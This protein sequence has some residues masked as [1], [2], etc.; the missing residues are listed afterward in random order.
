MKHKE[1]IRAFPAPLKTFTQP[2]TPIIQH[3]ETQ[4]V[5]PKKCRVFATKI[6]N[7][8]IV[9]RDFDSLGLV[10]EEQASR[11][12]LLYNSD[13]NQNRYADMGIKSWKAGYERTN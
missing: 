10:P 7:G 4:E 6:V 5:N 11:I 9:R 3:K 2:Y 1:T 8:K 13:P 12:V